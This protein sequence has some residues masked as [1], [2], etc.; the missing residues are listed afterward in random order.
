MANKIIYTFEIVDFVE[1]LER[2][3][4]QNVLPNIRTGLMRLNEVCEIQ[5]GL[6]VKSKLSL[7]TSGGV[8]VIRLQD[9]RAGGTIALDALVSVNL[10]NVADMYVARSGDVVFRSRGSE[11][12]AAHISKEFNSF[13]VALMPVLILRSFQSIVT[14]E[15][16]SWLIN[17]PSSQEY[18]GRITRNPTTTTI[19]ISDLANLEIDI[20]DLRTQRLISRTA[21]LV[22]E[23][24]RI[25]HRL[26]LMT[27]THDHRCLS[28]IAKSH[29]QNPI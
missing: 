10:S 17:R 14:P 28:M 29:G 24:N 1:K 26:N 6:T 19:S 20:P 23:R 15:Y 16:L 13:A 4:I 12:L 3:N 9:I 27:K 22:E 25:Q 21:A 11:N 18:F 2:M 8:R 5:S 7:H